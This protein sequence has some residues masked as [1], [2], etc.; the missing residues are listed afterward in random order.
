MMFQKPVRELM[1]NQM[2]C[3]ILPAD[4]LIQAEMKEGSFT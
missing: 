2:D 4:V 1:E 3:N